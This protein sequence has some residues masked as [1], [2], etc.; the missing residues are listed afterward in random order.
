MQTGVFREAKEPPEWT[1]PCRGFL[2]HVLHGEKEDVQLHSKLEEGEEE[3]KKQTNNASLTG[4]KTNKYQAKNEELEEQSRQLHQG[5]PFFQN[6]EK[7][8]QEED[9]NTDTSSMEG[10]EL[11]DVI[12][13]QES[14]GKVYRKDN[15][16]VFKF[17][18]VSFHPFPLILG[19]DSRFLPLNTS[20]PPSLSLQKLPLPS[21]LDNNCDGE[22]WLLCRICGKSF[23]ELAKLMCHELVHGQEKVRSIKR[24]YEAFVVKNTSSRNSMSLCGE[25]GPDGK[26]RMEHLDKSTLSTRSLPGTEE[27]TGDKSRQ[28]L[29]IPQSQMR[30]PPESPLDAESSKAQSKE[31]PYQ[32]TICG[33]RFRWQSHLVIHLGSHTGEREFRCTECGKTFRQKASLECHLRC[34]T[35]ERPYECT[36]CGKDFTL[37]SSLVKHA[38]T[39][40]GERPY[41]CPECGKDFKQKYGLV[42]HLRC[43][44]GERPHKCEECGKDFIHRSSLV[45]HFRWH[46]VEKPYK[47]RDC[48]KFFKEKAEMDSHMCCQGEEYCI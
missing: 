39:H 37:K 8:Q 47:C 21:H 9:L 15:G 44:T 42:A 40:T 22:I 48:G 27:E 12:S 1:S 46:M 34:H 20:G 7:L 43:H 24:H 2:P 23:N 32:C 28:K 45:K 14:S 4:G 18:K 19:M 11:I 26:M 17:P 6:K 31:K 25:I 16:C 33:K 3:C 41:E 29:E 30:G 10:Q 5:I 36:E 35:G 38:R 13:E